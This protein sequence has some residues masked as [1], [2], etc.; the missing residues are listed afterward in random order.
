MKKCIVIPDSFKGT[1]SSAQVCRGMEEVLRRF[2]PDCQ[3]ISIPVADGGEGTV[4]CFLTALPGERVPVTASGPFG[5]PCT[6]YYGRFG[7]RAVLEMAMFAGLP[8]AE[9]RLNPAAASTF[10]VG[11]AVKRAVLDGCTRILLGLGGSCTNDG[12]AGMAAALGVRFYDED[13]R[14][15]VPTGGTLCRI[16]RMDPEP[17]R[18]FL[19]DVQ[20]TAMCDIDNPLCGESG[21]AFVFAPQKGADAAMVRQ[22]DAG[23]AHLAKIIDRDCH[24]STGSCSAGE[25]ECSVAEIPGSGAAGGM[26]A[27]VLALGGALRPGIEAVLDMV[28]FD[29]LL[30]G[31]DLVLTG[32]GRIDGQSLRG[33]V[34]SGV[35][36]RAARQG[37]PV[38]A[39]VGDIAPGA[40]GAYD[41]GVTAMV[42]I[43]RRPIDFSL[44]RD[45]SEASLRAATEDFCR[46]WRAAA[47]R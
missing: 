10:G 14:S 41:C 31:A 22:L 39:V 2:F 1:L 26:G 46:I 37:V 25:E 28:G 6:G 24:C 17:A 44:C 18:V 32:E 43:S 27:G 36:S 29:G 23:L 40:E 4:D 33:K 38:V 5:E 42:S 45:Q 13:G 9:G 30:Q 21:A 7:D 16:A 19:K 11:E 35:A 15:F 34:I 3:V 47:C 12:G 8:Q 20:L